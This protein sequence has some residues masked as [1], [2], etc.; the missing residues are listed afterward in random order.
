MEPNNIDLIKNIIDTIASPLISLA[1]VWLGW[2][3][4]TKAQSKQK[5]IDDIQERITALQEIMKVT[6]NIPKGVNVEELVEICKKNTELYNSLSHRLV[7]LLGLRI[8]LT[9]IIEKEIRDFIDFEFSPLFHSSVGTY[10]LATDANT[11][12]KAAI[13]IRDIVNKTEK[14]LVKKYDALNK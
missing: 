8:E 6:E 14:I 7:R 5:M 11:F 2:I 9:P 4:A 12:V 10:T 3:L 13:K 1:G